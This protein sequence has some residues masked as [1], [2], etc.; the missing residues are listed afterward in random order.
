MNRVY[1]I[2]FLFLIFASC[3]KGG[4]IPDLEVSQETV[5]VDHQGHD[6]TGKSPVI[7]LTANAIWEATSSSDWLKTNISTGGTRTLVTINVNPN[8]TGNERQ[9][10][11][12]FKNENAEAI[13]NVIQKAGEVDV[14]Q[15]NY[16]LPIIFHVIYNEEDL[17]NPDLKKRRKALNSED[18]QKILYQ[19]N[20]LFGASPITK[21]EEEQDAK[22][23]LERLDHTPKIDTRIR[24]TLAKE[25]PD[26][27]KLPNMGVTRKIMAEKSIDPYSVLNSKSGEEYHSMNWPIDKY[28]N[29]FVFPFSQLGPSTE[30]GMTLGISSMPRVHDGHPISGLEALNSVVP[31]FDNYNHC[32]VLNADAF[33]ER[34][35][36]E[37]KTF[38]GDRLG[39]S[40]LAHELGHYLG[41]L[42]TFAESR[43]GNQS[44]PIDDCLDSDFCEDTYSYNRISY[45][46]TAND[47]ISSTGNYYSRREGLLSRTNCENIR[48]F[49]ANIMDYEWSY[50]DR[51]TNQQMA[52]MRH[53]LYYS[54]TVPGT[55]LIEFDTTRSN[56][57]TDIRPHFSVCN[58]T[59]TH[60]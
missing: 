10:T 44:V 14:E 48:F 58:A 49:S 5:E 47:I 11:I 33:E 46:R 43:E 2:L 42:H 55:K 36:G 19:V 40:T 51:F 24:F 7:M 31:N 59:C 9:G 45:V 52:R 23:L 15:I 17:N 39:F 60:H 50:S 57:F 26:G 8:F 18:L 1:W 41:L 6:A 16:E 32:I 25:D 4:K 28:I 21:E 13:I 30:V 22:D 20:K 35:Y 12:T 53:V 27:R 34:V 56:S 37:G 54:P 3:N 29:V 38:L